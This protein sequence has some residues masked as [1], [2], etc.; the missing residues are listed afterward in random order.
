MYPTKTLIYVFGICLCLNNSPKRPTPARWWTATLF[1]KNM[2][3]YNG[4]TKLNLKNA[5]KWRV[6]SKILWVFGVGRGPANYS[7]LVR[8]ENETVHQCFVKSL[9]G[10]QQDSVGAGGEAWRVA[11]ASREGE[12]N[13]EQWHARGNLVEGSFSKDLGVPWFVNRWLMFLHGVLWKGGMMWCANS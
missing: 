3:I 10:P 11:G 5:K 9:P 2:A 4:N 1:K 8:A 13:S 12:M 7:Q 6:K